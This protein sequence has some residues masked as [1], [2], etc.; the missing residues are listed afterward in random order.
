[1]LLPA[2]TSQPGNLPGHFKVH[3]ALFRQST[4]IL[5]GRRISLAECVKQAARAATPWA[6]RWWQGVARRALEAGRRP[7]YYSAWCNPQSEIRN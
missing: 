6:G 3:A 1:M 7:A 2:A 5:T 4:K